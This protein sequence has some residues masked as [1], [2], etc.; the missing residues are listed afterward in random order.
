MIK[1]GFILTVLV[2]CKSWGEGSRTLQTV[3]GWRGILTKVV[4][5]CQ[6]LQVER[7]NADQRLIQEEGES[8]LGKDPSVNLTM[9]QLTVNYLQI[10]GGWAG[11]QQ[12]REQGAW[13][14]YQMRSIAE[15]DQA[16]I[17]RTEEVQARGCLEI[18]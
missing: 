10:D 4:Y 1:S 9:M 15:A 16:D 17:R 14:V 13:R 3:A 8:E 5:L 6:L 2:D 11:K 7:L 18:H 12:R